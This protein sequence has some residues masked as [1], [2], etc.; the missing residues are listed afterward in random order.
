MS[1][2]PALVVF[3]ALI[4]LLLASSGGGLGAASSSPRLGADLRPRKPYDMYVER[5]ASGRNLRFANAVVNLGK[6]P[7]ELT[8]SDAD[9]DGD[10]TSVDRVV[11]QRIF[12]DVD[13]DGSFDRSLDNESVERVAGC[14]RWH[15]EHGH[16]HFDDFAKYELLSLAN[17]VV[18]DPVAPPVDKVSFCLVD[19]QR[20]HEL[21][22]SPTLQHYVGEFC[23][24][25]VD[26]GISV[27]WADVY[28]GPTPG[29]EIDI[30]D[31]PRGTYCLRTTV[32]P[33]GALKERNESNNVRSTKVVLTKSGVEA[34]GG[35]RS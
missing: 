24:Q 29:Q 2:R 3:G 18:G 1:L 23:R 8:P 22:G 32:D 31:V 30:S 26:T 21:S 16:W 4:A 6:G 12:R 19:T 14:Q 27:G 20:I 11:A 13:N 34:A 33:S 17:G 15:D 9:C 5:T 28:A 7:M 10:E 25:G 35:C